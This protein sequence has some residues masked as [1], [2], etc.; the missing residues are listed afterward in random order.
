M[1]VYSKHKLFFFIF[2]GLAIPACSKSNSDPSTEAAAV[3]VYYV[4]PNGSDGNAGTINA[5][6]K[7][8][9]AA[10]NKAVPGDTVIARG[11]TYY[12]RVNFPKSGTSDKLITLKA[13]AGEKPVID[14]STV[15]VTGWMALVTLSAVRYITCL[16]YT[17]PSPR[18]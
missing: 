10:L 5:P 1:N 13:Y 7:T 8:I 3:H 6:F 2:L 4:S 9:T 12:E 14:G 11:G 17:S 15:T 18:D 16:L